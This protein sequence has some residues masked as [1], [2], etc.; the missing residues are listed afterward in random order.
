MKNI[1][2]IIIISILSA[3]GLFAQ[4]DEVN[5]NLRLAAYGKIDEVRAVIPDLL[6]KYPNDAG[7]KLLH[8][9]ILDD[10]F[11]ALEVYQSIIKN[12]PESEW[13]DHAY[14]RIVQFYAVLGDTAKAQAE[15]A[16]FRS[17]YPASAFITPAS[18]VVRTCVNLV[19]KKIKNST[20]LT[21]ISLSKQENKVNPD[22][23]ASSKP[24]TNPSTN[25]NPAINP[26]KIA[27]SV[28]LNDNKQK[29][30]LEATTQPNKNKDDIEKLTP[31]K[32]IEKNKPVENDEITLKS[33]TASE[34]TKNSEKAKPIEAVEKVGPAFYGLQV[35]IYKDKNTAEAEKNKFL[36]RRLRTQ[37]V[38]K[39][40]TGVIMFAVVIG[41]YSS[42]ESAEE[43]KKIVSIQCGCEPMIYKK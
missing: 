10:A 33:T 39:E 4:K 8:G 7:V 19:S 1:A 24:N 3:A 32:R 42:M 36:V 40:V 31:D 15:L 26:D 20:S 25:S 22:V 2:L 5:K 34:S 35:G 21:A 12:Y 6:A 41:H 28:E 37:I 27:A 9:T 16:N 38:E 43:G 17:R 11:L 30:P 18:D 23:A 14:W 13:A 29:K